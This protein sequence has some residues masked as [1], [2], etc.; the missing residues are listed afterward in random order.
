MNE[1]AACNSDNGKSVSVEQELQTRLRTGGGTYDVEWDADAAVT[2]IGSLVYFGQYLSTGG[3]F[4]GLCADCPLTYSSPNAPDKRDV[5]GT[6]MLSIL[7]G[8]TRYAHINALRQDRVSADV[9]GMKKIISEDSVR[10]AFARGE[11]PEWEKWLGKHERRV[12]EPLLTE[13]YIIDIDNTVNPL[14]GHQEGA[15]VSYNPKKPGR[16]SHNYHTYF[17]GALRVVLGVDV[18]GGKSHSGAPQHAWIVGFA[19]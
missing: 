19:R 3:L 12:W 6:A 13:A 16:P 18:Q 14:Y 9:L 8:Q 7:N 4:D 11:M 15:E 2:P 5:V 10:R 1:V 17:I